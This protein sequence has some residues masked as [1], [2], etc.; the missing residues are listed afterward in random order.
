MPLDERN[1]PKLMAA[2]VAARASIDNL[3]LEIA[4]QK[5]P[6]DV[7]AAVRVTSGKCEHPNKKTAMGGHWWCPDCGVQE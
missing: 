3:L 4:E 1:Y 5:T 6:D 2:L 7:L